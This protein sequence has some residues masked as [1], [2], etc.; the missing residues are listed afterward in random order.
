M[1][2]SILIRKSDVGL[3]KEKYIHCSFSFLDK[4]ADKLVEWVEGKYGKSL[5]LRDEMSGEYCYDW[6]SGDILITVNLVKLSGLAYM[7]FENIPG[8]AKVVHKEIS[9]EEFSKKHLKQ[10]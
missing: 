10:N 3:E 8:Y 2:G 9:I 6:F 7:T 5:G 1:D 4:K